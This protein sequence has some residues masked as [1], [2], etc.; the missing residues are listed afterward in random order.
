MG[1]AIQMDKAGILEIADLFVCNKADHP[2]QHELMR[3]LK[4]VAGR[5]PVIETIASRGQG[6]AELLKACLGQ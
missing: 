4:E 2:G 3:D 1:D 6:I 5:K